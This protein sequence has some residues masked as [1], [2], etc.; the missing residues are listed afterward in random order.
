METDTTSLSIPAWIPN[1]EILGMSAVLLP[2]R[3]AHQIDWDGFD[4][5]LIRTRDCG[6]IPA[7]NM[8]T[9]YANLIDESTRT[10]VLDRTA[11]IC[12]N[13]QFV[14]GVF[15][16]S[17]PNQTFN[18]DAYASGLD[19]ITSRGGL[20][21]VFQSFGL[22]SLSDEDLIDAYRRFGA[23]SDRFLAFEL[24][25]LFAPFGKIY[26]LDVYEELI[27]IQACIGAKHSSLSRSQEWQRLAIRDRV[28]PDFRV[29]TGNDLAIDMVFYGSDY[30]LGLSTF[31][32]ELFALR[33]RWWCAG[34]ARAVELNDILQ[35]LGFFAFRDPVPAYKHSAAMFLHQ[36]GLI[37]S[38]YTYPGSPM[39]PS[40]DHE[41]LQKILLQLQPY[42]DELN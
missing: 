12:A 31:A 1:R 39:R 23:R 6:L 41:I 38:N 20:P 33:D 21:I 26:E 10:A 25:P 7:V 32:P 42:W 35:Y 2:M 4:A 34:D 16:A 29:L 13:Q 27:Q 14:A 28:R 36:R 3:D 11:D 8:D 37:A 19:A 9:G 40:S 24:S 30:L 18:F 5:N 15:V 22:T 17:A